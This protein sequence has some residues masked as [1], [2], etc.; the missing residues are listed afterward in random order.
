MGGLIDDL[1]ALSRFTRSELHVTTVDLT[2]IAREVAAELQS[3]DPLRQAEWVIADG[4]TARGDERLLHVA[5]TNLLGNAWK[6]SQHTANAWIELTS[7]QVDGEDRYIVRDNGAGFDMAHADKLFSSFG[8]LHTSDE[9]E[10][11][12]IGLATV[13]RIVHRHGGHIAA[14]GAVGRGQPSPSPCRLAH[15]E[16]RMALK[17]AWFFWWT[18]PRKMSN[19][20]SWLWRNPIQIL[21]S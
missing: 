15:E 3:E 14:E 11:T 1:L 4:M 6:F 5:L 20:R 12:G 19:S 8:R 10:G 13:Q 18:T 7:E 9:F 17:K 2:R 21:T 16:A